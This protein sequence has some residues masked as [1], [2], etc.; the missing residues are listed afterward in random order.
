MVL[1]DRVVGLD[2]SCI[3]QSKKHVIVG[4]DCMQ[5]TITHRESLEPQSFAGKHRRNSKHKMYK[6]DTA[7]PYV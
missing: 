2:C 3:A 4:M 5:W 1:A 6:G 7:L